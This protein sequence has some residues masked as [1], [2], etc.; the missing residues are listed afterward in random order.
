MRRFE[1]KNTREAFDDRP[2]FS[3][4]RAKF[5]GSLENRVVGNV[6]SFAPAVRY[7][8]PLIVD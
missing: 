2:S 8:Q 5:L 7:R 1:K 3:V 4:S 6:S